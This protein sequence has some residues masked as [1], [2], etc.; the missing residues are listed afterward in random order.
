MDNWCYAK[1]AKVKV[2]SKQIVESAGQMFFASTGV[3]GKIVINEDAAVFSSRTVA[4]Q[5]CYS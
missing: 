2:L 1:L 4:V 5:L 3:N